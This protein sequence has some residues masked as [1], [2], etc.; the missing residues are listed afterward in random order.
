YNNPP[1]PPDH[2]ESMKNYMKNLQP[3]DYQNGGIFGW[4]PFGTSKKCF[5]N[6]SSNHRVKTK[7]WNE[8]LL[9]YTSI[10]VKVKHQKKGLWWYAKETDEV[11]LVINQA[12]FAITYP[13]QTP[14]YNALPTSS[15]NNQRLYYYNGK[16]YDN[17]S[18]SYAVATG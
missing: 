17:F 14:N 8:D 12:M 3:C 6:H 9:F 16:F 7:Y 15:S 13:N 5:S 18:A 11:A 10:G 2:T 4:N 1:P